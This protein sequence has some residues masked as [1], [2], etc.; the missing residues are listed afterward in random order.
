[1]H[2][3]ITALL[4]MICLTA[5]AQEKQFTHQDTLKGSITP[6]RAWWDV[7]HYDLKVTVDPDNK[8]ISGS[9]TITYKVLEP[10]QT[11]Q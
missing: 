10:Y 5:F 4:G 6:E 11:L 8:F 1:M 3:L 7:T 9:N 2:K